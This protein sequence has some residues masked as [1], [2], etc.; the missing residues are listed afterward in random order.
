LAAGTASDS[1]SNR[2]PKRTQTSVFR[3][4]ASGIAANRTGNNL[5][6]KIDDRA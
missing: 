2:I 4:C 1:T 3:R 6:D 5:D